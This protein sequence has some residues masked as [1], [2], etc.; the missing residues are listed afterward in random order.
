MQANA[1][2]Q[3]QWASHLA[4]YDFT[5]HMLLLTAPGQETDPPLVFLT[6]KR[7]RFAGKEGD[8]YFICVY[9]SKSYTWQP[10]HF[11]QHTTLQLFNDYRSSD[12]TVP[13]YLCQQGYNIGKPTMFNC[14]THNLATFHLPACA[15]DIFSNLALALK[16]RLKLFRWMQMDR[17]WQQTHP[18]SALELKLAATSEQEKWLDSACFYIVRN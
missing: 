3:Q 16:L 8:Y 15:V 10:L 13:L 7:A 5:T 18:L 11:I 14:Y 2:M 6:E 4:L 1:A 12:W 9:Y 17:K